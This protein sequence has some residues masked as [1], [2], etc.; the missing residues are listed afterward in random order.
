[1]I[2]GIARPFTQ[3]RLWGS[4]ILALAMPRGSPG[5][6][7]DSNHLCKVPLFQPNGRYAVCQRYA[8]K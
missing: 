7:A 2:R 3:R 8:H 4:V 6:Q 1:M 5:T